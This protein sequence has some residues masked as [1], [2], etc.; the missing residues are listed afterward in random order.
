MKLVWYGERGVERSELVDVSGTL[1]D[2]SGEIEDITPETPASAIRFWA[3]S[4]GASPSWRR[5]RNRNR[6][7]KVSRIDGRKKQE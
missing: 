7:L 1:R 4:T 6:R 3:L 2:L 5:K